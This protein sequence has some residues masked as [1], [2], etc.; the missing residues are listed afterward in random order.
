MDSLV[1]FGIPV[2]LMYRNFHIICSPNTHPLHYEDH[3]LE[4]EREAMDKILDLE[5]SAA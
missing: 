1:H 5:N 4:V 2:V 3:H